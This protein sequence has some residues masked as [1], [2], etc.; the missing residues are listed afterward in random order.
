MIVDGVIIEDGSPADIFLKK[1]GILDISGLVK[2]AVKL[3]YSDLKSF[4]KDT[5]TEEQQLKL[6]DDEYF[7]IFDKKRSDENISSSLDED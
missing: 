2:L 3:G 6:T 5:L 7:K 4:F 1:L